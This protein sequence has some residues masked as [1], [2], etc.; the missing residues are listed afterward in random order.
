M[1][2]N[3]IAALAAGAVIFVTAAAFIGKEKDSVEGKMF[4]VTATENKKGKSGKPIQDVIEFRNGKLKSKVVQDEFGFGQLKYELTVDSTYKDEDEDVMYVEFEAT[5]K[6]KEEQEL[7]V[8]G[9]IDG[10][11]CEGSM[12]LTDKKG[13]VKKHFDFVGSQKDKKKQK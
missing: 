13:K 4:K 3:R 5:A 7:K 9:T 10:A 2:R 8:T 1:T 12:E 11:G 6:D